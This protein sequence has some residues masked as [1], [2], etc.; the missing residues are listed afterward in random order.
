MP[1][2]A[3]FMPADVP[4]PVIQRGIIVVCPV[5]LDASMPVRGKLARERPALQPAVVDPLLR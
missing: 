3:R 1:G 5:F 2:H 4:V